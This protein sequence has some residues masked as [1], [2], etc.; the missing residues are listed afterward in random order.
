MDYCEI[1]NRI[2]QKKQSHEHQRTDYIQY[3]DFCVL[4]AS[5]V[6]GLIDSNIADIIST[7][8]WGVDSHGY[9]MANMGGKMVRLHDVVMAL[10]YNEKPQNCYVDHINFDKLDNRI[11][12][13]RFV[14]P[15]ESS[16]NM[17][18]KANNTSGATG[19]SR[20]K[21]GGFRAYITVHKKRIELGT[22][23]TLQEAASVRSEAETR[24]GFKT[25]PNN[26]AFL[27]ELEN[28]DEHND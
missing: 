5:G 24:L 4:N 22:Y 1:K 20:T 19:V 18:L 21:H 11:Q 27:I 26:I 15:E 9:L 8:K 14:T 7:R 28:Y 10:N 17:P 16:L 25:R 23:K 2:Y 12:N 3:G 13:L 6:Y